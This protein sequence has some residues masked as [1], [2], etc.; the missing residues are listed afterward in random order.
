MPGSRRA[1]G[2]T[3]AAGERYAA[4]VS[5]REDFERRLLALVRDYMDWLDEKHPD[6]WEIGDFLIAYDV[7][8]APTAD[9]ELRPWEHPRY[10]GWDSF[11][12]VSSSARGHWLTEALVNAA[13]GAVADYDDADDEQGDD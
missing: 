6:G 5:P 4:R 11:V 9:T 13:N 3:V 12:S 7:R 10:T 1:S 2:R 8:T